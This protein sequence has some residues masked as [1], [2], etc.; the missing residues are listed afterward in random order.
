[1]NRPRTALLV[2]AGAAALSLTGC[3]AAEPI[4]FTSHTVVID[5][6]TAGEYATGHL[7]GAVNLDLNGGDLTAAVPAL[8]DQDDYIVY[9]ASGNRS[10]Q[11][12]A[13]LEDAGLEVVDAGSIQ[14]ASD[15]TGLE[16]VQ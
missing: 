9:C 4:A 12:A 14:H 2:A 5:V 10:G 6:R 11:A 8:D 16:I 3:A 1:M 13:L 15:V 7:A